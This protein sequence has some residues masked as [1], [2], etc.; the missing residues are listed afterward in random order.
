MRP[1]APAHGCD[2]QEQNDDPR[3][4]F[5]RFFCRPHFSF[6]SPHPPYMR[7]QTLD[8]D[9]CAGNLCGDVWL[10]L[11]ILWSHTRGEAF[12]NRT[13]EPA[14]AGRERQAAPGV[15]KSE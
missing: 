8:E 10:A 1:F 7:S 3:R 9:L 11:W 15:A 12:A 4:Y 6:P 2:R 5:L 14:I 13:R